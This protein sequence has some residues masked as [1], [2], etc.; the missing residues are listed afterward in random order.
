[1]QFA[2]TVP[3]SPERVGFKMQIVVNPTSEMPI[4][5]QIRRH[6]VLGELRHR[7]EGKSDRG[8][9][10]HKGR[11]E[12]IGNERVMVGSKNISNRA[13]ELIDLDKQ[14]LGIVNVWM[15]SALVER[16]VKPVLDQPSPRIRQRAH[17]GSAT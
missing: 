16:V 13:S 10:L 3:E 15:R 7:K 1:M 8:R 2:A 4:M 17:I 6:R 9:I 12:I 5:V 14:V 11:I